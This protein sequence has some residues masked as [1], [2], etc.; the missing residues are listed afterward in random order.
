MLLSLSG[1]TRSYVKMYFILFLLFFF[2]GFRVGIN[3]YT[4][5]RD[6]VKCVCNTLSEKNTLCSQ[7]SLCLYRKIAPIIMICRYAR[8]RT[9]WHWIRPRPR[10]R[11]RRTTIFF[12]NKIV[13]I[14]RCGWRFAVDSHTAGNKI[15]WTK[16][17]TCGTCTVAPMHR[18]R[19]N[20][21]R[22]CAFYGKPKKKSDMH[23]RET[24]W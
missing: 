13:G 2:V 15:F 1:Y 4:E 23:T 3:S 14:F 8:H 22:K 11:R 7:F 17:K 5:F 9:I 24:I 19:E 20:M 21:R 10:R 12:P 16:K 6:S 18:P